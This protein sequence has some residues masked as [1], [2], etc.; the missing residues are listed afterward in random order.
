LADEAQ[1]W[2]RARSK[3]PAPIEAN[4]VKTLLVLSQ[5]KPCSACG[6]R[7]LYVNEQAKTDTPF[8]CGACEERR[9][10]LAKQCRKPAAKGCPSCGSMAI[11]VDESLSHPRATCGGCLATW[12]VLPPDK[13]RR[14]AA[15]QEAPLPLTRPS[16][17]MRVALYLRALVSTANDNAQVPS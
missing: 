5:W 10:S 8:V 4:L 12:S 13:R 3:P 17:P 11:F 9:E 7:T 6:A 1:R 2:E 15:V 14:P 16:L